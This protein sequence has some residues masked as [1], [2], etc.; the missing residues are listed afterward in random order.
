M[1]RFTFPI[2]HIYLLLVPLVVAIITFLTAQGLR[3]AAAVTSGDY[4]VAFLILLYV[5][6]FLALALGFLVLR[7]VFRLWL[8]RRQRRTGS[9]LRTRMAMMFVALSLL[10]T[11][12]I[13]ILSVNFL[14]RG[15]DSWFSDRIARAMDTAL[16]V[17]RAYYRESQ[18]NVRHDAEGIVRNRA[19]A[20]AL[21]LEDNEAVAAI[22][23]V[24]RNA[25]GLDEVIILRPDGTS[26][27]K[28]GGLPFDPLPDLDALVEGESRALVVTSDA[29][30][31]VRAF[32]ALDDNYVLATGHWID[33]QILG[34]LE[35]IEAVYVDY[36][37][38][39]ASHGLLKANHT[40]TLALIALLLLLAAIWSGFRI[41]DDLTDP[42]AELI[43][44]AR[45]V[46]IGD[47]SVTLS[48]TGD[49]EL[50]TLMAAFNAMTRK[51]QENHEEL[52]ATNAL[53]EERRRFM[54]AI[55]QHIS[56]GVISVN[57]GGEITLMNP[58]A[59][60]LLGLDSQ[61][62]IG[63]HH[64]AVLPDAMLAP[65]A[66]RDAR[67]A[68]SNGAE[69]PPA[70][71]A[72]QFQMQIQGADRIHTLTVRITPLVDGSGEGQGFIATFDDISDILLAQRSHAWSEVARR[73]AHEI[74]NP[75]TPIQLWAQRLRR[76]YMK[77]QSESCP[78][79]QVLDEGTNAIISQ[80][81]ELRVLVNEFSTF[82]R[83]PRPELALNDLHAGIGEVLQLHRA[84]LE[85]FS[86]T[87]EFAPDLPL[88]PH[89]RGQLKQVFTN[90]ISNA[91]AAIRER[92]EARHL[93]ICTEVTENGEGVRIQ[94]ADSGSG[95]PPK[96]RDRVFEPYFTTKATGVG[97]GMAIVKKIIEDHG[98]TIRIRQS[99][100]D[101][102]L[103]EIHLPLTQAISAS[104][105][106][107]V[108]PSREQA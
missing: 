98:G 54:A 13:A 20:S 59:G 37:N 72:M 76:K 64:R 67:R 83:L 102:A 90:V 106:G 49:D 65:L 9:M 105:T 89:D 61:G 85:K 40:V 86:V 46:A 95:I 75:L 68:A 25:R 80:V 55:V 101:G 29:G 48:V 107:A 26:I 14:N 41:A 21:A 73:I 99:Q 17:S 88:F 84:E 42:I 78:D 15:V 100:W 11:L 60:A 1:K 66:R 93:A 33:R 10:P 8:D 36:K 53:L 96:D 104:S 94:I 77:H 50:A 30:D 16:G 62:V 52:Q 97:L 32:V 44:G 2:R 103:V 27:A 71:S 7:H 6:L 38:L 12:I 19:V 34:Q 5:N 23:E 58:A 69:P 31:R 28:A 45:K 56:A 24:E 91:M 82:A 81:E 74:K 57:R 108:A 3:G 4:G 51:L 70:E 18:R 87:T 39:R 47:L 63:Q 43:V 92:N 79:W 22:L 35:N